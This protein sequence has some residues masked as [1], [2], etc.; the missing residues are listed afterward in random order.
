MVKIALNNLS[1]KIIGYLPDDIN[2]KIDSALSY[3]IAEYRWHPLVKCGK[4]DGIVRLYRKNAG[5]SFYSGLLSLVTQ[6]LD[7]NKIPYTKSDERVRP[8][9]NLPHLVFSPPIGFKERDYQKF[10]IDRAVQRTRGILKMATGS[11]KTLVVAQMISE[12]KTAPFMFY[13]L[14]EDLLRQAY[15]VL[16][17]TLNEPIGIIGGGE[18]DIKNINV[19]TIQTSIM[20]LHAGEKIKISDYKFDDEDMWNEKDLLPIEKKQQLRNLI[21]KLNGFYFDECHHVAAKCAKEVLSASPNAFWKFAGSAT[22]WREDGAEMIIQALFGKKIVDISASYLIKKKFLVKPYIIFDPIEDN[23]ELHSYPSIYKKCISENKE[24]NIRI[25][26]I[27]KYL[28]S[29]GLTVLILVQQYKQGDFLK[30]ILPEDIDFLTGKMS[31][32]A[33][34]K[35]LQ[36]IKNG[37]KKCIVGTTL[38][39]EGIDCPCLDVVLMAGGGASSTRV[40][41][42]IGRTLRLNGAKDKAL[43]VYFE[44]DAKH[45]EKHAKKAKK[46]MKEEPEFKIIKSS[47]GDFIYSDINDI[48]GFGNEN[49]TANGSIFNI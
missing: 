23:C 10:T 14:T 26:N 34:K 39:D 19:C 25:S 41:Q 49:S 24:F 8:I 11:G 48:F 44:H 40:Y 31:R 20:A 15:E 18:F 38:F 37:N 21:S 1:S 35:A 45:L 5:Q 6:I 29:K 12:I 47:G 28:I 42:R 4:W 36:E 32:N 2:K 3:R 17:A 22:P 43:V 33:R 30:T 27:A 13:V 46:I 7:E 16:S 9:Q